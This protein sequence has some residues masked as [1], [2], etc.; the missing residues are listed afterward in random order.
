LKTS[1]PGVPGASMAD[2][3]GDSIGPPYNRQDERRGFA[4]GTVIPCSDQY[5][6][7][8]RSACRLSANDYSRVLGRSPTNFRVDPS[9]RWVIDMLKSLEKLDDASEDRFTQK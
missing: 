2:G 7:V 6:C 8:D 4:F 5:D 9:K 3:N 1:T